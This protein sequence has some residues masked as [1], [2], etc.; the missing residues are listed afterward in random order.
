MT[1]VQIAI[2]ANRHF[3]W[4]NTWYVNLSG[5]F[6]LV[7]SK[8][9]VL[10]WPL[11]AIN[12]KILI[13]QIEHYY[14]LKDWNNPDEE[15]S[16]E[17]ST[18]GIVPLTQ[19]SIDDMELITTIGIGAFGRVELVRPIGDETRSFALK[20]MAK[21]RIVEQDQQEHIKNEKNLLMTLNNDF[22]VKCYQ[23]FR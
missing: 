10:A 17:E 13:L 14:F 3:F 8:P 21:F 15:E 18:S 11:T 7:Y 23:S 22:I 6:Y 19:Y 5:C 2:I 9:D 20:K 12:C 4:V 1:K 16:E